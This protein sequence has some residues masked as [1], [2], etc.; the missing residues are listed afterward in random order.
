MR[1]ALRHPIAPFIAAGMI[2]E[3][4]AFYAAMPARSDQPPTP[5]QQLLG[6]AQ[7]PGGVLF[8]LLFGH[9]IGHQIDKLPRLLASAVVF[10]GLAIVFLFQSALM[11]LPLWLVHRFWRTLRTH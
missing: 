9:G 1:S 7:F 3:V 2:L 11:A 6:Y 10:T 8:S 5:F 4:I